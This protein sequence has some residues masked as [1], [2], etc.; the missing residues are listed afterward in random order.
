MKSTDGTRRFDRVLTDL[1]IPPNGGCVIRSQ[2]LLPYV[3][4]TSTLPPSMVERCFV[5]AASTSAMCM[6]TCLLLVFPL[7]LPPCKRYLFFNGRYLTGPSIQTWALLKCGSWLKNNRAI[8]SCGTQCERAKRILARAFFSLCEPVSRHRTPNILRTC[9]L[10]E[11][12]EVHEHGVPWEFSACL[13]FP[14]LRMAQGAPFEANNHGPIELFIRRARGCTANAAGPVALILDRK[15]SVVQCGRRR[16]S[17]CSRQRNVGH[18]IDPCSL[19]P[20]GGR[21]PSSERGQ[22]SEHQLEFFYRSPRVVRSN[23]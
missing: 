9:R 11:S 7:A 13:F 16:R 6:M 8:C 5:T 14:S 12:H 17:P 20:G 3:I 22:R 4:I 21:Q 18:K 2:N 10:P 15:G 23:H 1:L 19:P